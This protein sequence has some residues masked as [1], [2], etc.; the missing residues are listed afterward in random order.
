MADILQEILEKL[1]EE[2]EISSSCFEGANIILYTKNKDFFLDNKGIIR[3]LVSL[4]KKRIELRPEPSIIAEPK[5]AEKIIKSILPEESGITNIIFD[6]PRSYVIIESEKPGTAI[7]KEGELLKEIKSKTLW[8]PFVRRTPPIRSK[9]IENIRAVLYEESDFRRKFLNAVGSRIYHGWIRGKKEEWVRISFLGGARQ[10]GR[11]CLFL[12]TQES[13]VLLDCGINVAAQ[14]EDMYPIFDAPEFKIGEID[15]VIVGH[16]HL[17][18]CGVIP[19]LFKYGY[20]GPVYCT[21]PTRD[22]M[23]LLCLDYISVGQMEAK[24]QIYTVSD[25]KEMIKHTICLNYEEVTDITPDIR[26]TFYNAGHTLGSSLVHL[27]IGNGLH[28]LLYSGDCNYEYSNLLAPAITRF[29]RI[30]TVIIESTYGGR[31]DFLPPRKEC[32]TQLLEI[33]N[34]TIKRGGKVLMPVLGVGRSQEIMIILERA[35][36]EKIIPNVPIYLQGLVWDVNAIHTAYPEFFNSTV[37]KSVFLEDKNPFL[38]PCFKHI[39]SQKETEQLIHSG[40]PCIIMATSG[41]LIGGAS[42]EYFKSL[43]ENPK[44]SLILTCYQPEGSLGRRLQNGEKEISFAVGNGRSEVTRVQCEVH[45]ISGFSGHSSRQQ[46][47]NYVC[48]L[49][50]QPRRIIV[51]HGESSK[52]LDLASSLHKLTKIE[53]SA[54]RNLDVLRLR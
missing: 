43:A 36:H 32:E 34:R 16:A 30:E 45:I 15:A 4:F 54:P 46:L 26:A 39:I 28:N 10:V 1:P 6:Q 20:K 23:A 8:A 52:C 53:T 27:H 29:P 41:M 42:L 31:D 37:R 47:I 22:T 25:I 49:D 38:A 14:G 18:H 2:A 33:I 19:L 17:D 13:R 48:H 7:G 3:E 12:Q 51:N 5:K 11:S 40:E 35:I 9:I 24:E 50:P 44:H 21:E